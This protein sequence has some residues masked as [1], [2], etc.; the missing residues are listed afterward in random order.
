MEGVCACVWYPVL[1]LRDNGIMDDDEEEE[2]GARQAGKGKYET[3]KKK[4]KG[5]VTN[6]ST[7]LF[8]VGQ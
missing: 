4:N 8:T 1:I 3:V 7:V 2:K 5:G 6:G